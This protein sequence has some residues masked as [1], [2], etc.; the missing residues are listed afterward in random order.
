MRL[1]FKDRLLINVNE[2]GAYPIN[3]FTIVIAG[4]VAVS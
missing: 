2:N 4:T 3:I 1:L